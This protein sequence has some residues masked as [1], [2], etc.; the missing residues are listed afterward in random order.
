M[1]VEKRMFYHGNPTIQKIADV[2]PGKSNFWVRFKRSTRQG[3]PLV[4]DLITRLLIILSDFR[5]D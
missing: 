5:Y 2:L 3:I 1:A 4:K